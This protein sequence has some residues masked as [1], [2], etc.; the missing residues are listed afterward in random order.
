MSDQDLAA[1]EPPYFPVS[2]TKLVVMTLC[3]FGLYEVYW[4][5]K[6]WSLIK[7]RDAVEIMPFWR[8]FFSIF[9]CHG[10][11]KH[12]Q[13]TADKLGVK[14]FS[15][16]GMAAGWV[17]ASLLWR[18]PDPF[19]LVSMCALLFLLPVQNTVNEINAAAAPGHEPNSGFGGLNIVGVVVG[20]LLLV[21]GVVG[22]FMPDAAALP[23]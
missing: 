2:T 9:F 18:L 8:A 12:I 5:Y 16:E 21:L 3:T 10:C 20:G 23:K 13:T 19:W 1:P 22:A 6:N 4:F 17:I 15:A 14:S 11:F 7:K